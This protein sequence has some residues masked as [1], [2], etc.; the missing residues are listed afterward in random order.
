M[1]R[2]TPDALRAYA[3][4]ATHWRV[5]TEGER[6]AYLAYLRRMHAAGTRVVLLT[7]PRSPSADAV[8]PASL[9]QESVLLRDRL[10]KQEGFIEWEPGAMDDSLYCD[11]L[12][13]NQRGRAFYS[14]WLAKQLAVLLGA[15]SGV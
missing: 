12:H 1:Q 3:D 6:A 8:V 10:M 14:A 2:Q 4:Y 5:T 9:K 15:H 7:L 11:Q 13:V